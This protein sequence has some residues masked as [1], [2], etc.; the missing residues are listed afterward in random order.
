[1]TQ[2][3]RLE[4]GNRIVK[5]MVPMTAAASVGG[6]GSGNVPAGGSTGQLLA[7][8]SNADYDSEWVTGA[9]G[10]GALFG[11]SVAD[12][13]EAVRTP[14]V[15]DDLAAFVACRDAILA[16]SLLGTPTSGIMLV[17]GGLYYLSDRFD[18]KGVVLIG[19]HSAQPFGVGTLIRVA[20]NKSGIRLTRGDSGGYSRVEAIQLYGG[21]VDVDGA[22]EV[23]SYNA[24]D[25]TIG[26]GVEIACDWGTCIDVAS[27]FFGGSG[28]IIASSIGNCNSF[29]L[30]RC[31]SQYN[32][33][34][35]Y[36]V[37]GAD[38]NAGTFNTCSALECGGAG[39]LDYSFLGNTYIQCHVRDCGIDDP[40]T[41]GVGTGGPTGT[42]EY[43]NGSGDYY[44][45]VARREAQASTEIPGSVTDGTEAWRIFGGHPNC[46]TWVTGMAWVSAAPYQTDPNS[47]TSRN[48][49]LGCY[50]ESAQGPVQAS[51][52][53]LFVGGLLDEVGF[54]EGSTALWQ[55]VDGTGLV[56]HGLSCIANGAAGFVTGFKSLPIQA[57]SRAWDVTTPGVAQGS[58]H[59]NGDAT[60]DKGVALTFGTTGGGGLAAGAGIYAKASNA[61]GIRMY[62]ATTDN[63]GS[64]AKTAIA[65]DELGNVD[66][67]RGQ[68][69]VAGVVIGAAAP[70]NSVAGTAYTAV[71]ADAGKYLRFTNA[72]AVAF[73]IPA[74]GSVAYQIGTEIHGI[75]AGAGALTLV[76]DTG[77]TLNSSGADLTL[78]GQFSGFTAKKVGT[79]E[80][81]V[82]G[83]F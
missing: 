3:V 26:N 55:R 66:I 82:V 31:Q 67:V 54:D 44:Y 65:I 52:P 41:A 59:L 68:L 9:G 14:F 49:F 76:P 62:L 20:K 77:V 7:K 74:N 34:R 11:T 42:C 50:A 64:G 46:K 83:K 6:G 33:G 30:E 70:I 61:Y 81:D 38:A 63:F 72:A 60:N 1:M 4:S 40:T 43:P 28:F 18:T 53:G 37:S 71:L 51:A 27:Y 36:E 21:N 13:L 80:W 79:N 32:R 45:V 73:T 29:Y 24:G 22:G 69:K 16:D 75:Q 15:T 78:A 17:P 19:E 25:S 39:F 10:G 23:T 8:N 5:L 35:A 47:V 58:V 56:V 2:V 12:Y 57:I 48:V